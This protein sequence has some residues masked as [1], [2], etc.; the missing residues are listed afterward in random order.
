MRCIHGEQCHGKTDRLKGTTNVFFW[1]R[2]KYNTFYKRVVTVFFRSSSGSL[3]ELESPVFDGELQPTDKS[4]AKFVI[5]F[6]ALFVGF[7]SKL[8][9]VVLEL[10]AIILNI[11]FKRWRAE[12]M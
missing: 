6:D 12:V 7:I 1:H 2:I 5:T 10:G 11:D 4:G 3:E 8:W 9:I